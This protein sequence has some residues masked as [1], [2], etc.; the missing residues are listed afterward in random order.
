MTCDPPSPLPFHAPNRL[1]RFFDSVLRAGRTFVAAS[2][3]LVAS[4]VIGGYANC[5]GA[6]FDVTDSA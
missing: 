3:S 6:Q 1:G 5:D 4:L 2:E